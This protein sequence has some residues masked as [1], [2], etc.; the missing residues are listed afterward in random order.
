MH[1]KHVLEQCKILRLEYFM[2]SYLP[3]DF[4]T[5]KV[6]SHLTSKARLQSHGLQPACDAVVKAQG[7]ILGRLVQSTISSNEICNAAETEQRIILPFCD[8][9]IAL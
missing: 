6:Y 1:S 8:Y 5:V 7:E 9:K 3:P 2:H 4:R